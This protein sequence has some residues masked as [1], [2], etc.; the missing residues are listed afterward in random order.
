MTGE[1]LKARGEWVRPYKQGLQMEK[2]VAGTTRTHSKRVKSEVV[3]LPIGEGTT[4]TPRRNMS[5]PEHEIVV[6]RL[7]LSVR[8]TA[9]RLLLDVEARGLLVTL[10]DSEIVVRPDSQLTSADRNGIDEH[11]DQLAAMVRMCERPA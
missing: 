3:P 1:P 2:A 8:A 6:F 4:R 11:R 10:D 9:L 7:G 5:T